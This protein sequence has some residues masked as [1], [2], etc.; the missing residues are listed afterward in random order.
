[1]LNAFT[2]NSESIYTVQTIHPGPAW[3]GKTLLNKTSKEKIREREWEVVTNVLPLKS[4]PADDW[5]MMWGL[6]KENKRNR[7]TGI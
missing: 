6:G 4:H 1:M 2:V 7:T 3:K 5:K